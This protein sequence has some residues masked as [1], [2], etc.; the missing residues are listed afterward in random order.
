MNSSKGSGDKY[1]YLKEIHTKH[2]IKK[3]KTDI[4]ETEG[5][6]WSDEFDKLHWKLSIRFIPHK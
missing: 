1:G 5:S 4:D 3:L 2:K 6:V